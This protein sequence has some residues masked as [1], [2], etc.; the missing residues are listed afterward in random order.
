M[1]IRAM[2]E[3]DIA[4]ICK[5]VVVLKKLELFSDEDDLKFW[6]DIEIALSRWGHWHV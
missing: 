1:P 5:L 3:T 4:V 6:D 2:S